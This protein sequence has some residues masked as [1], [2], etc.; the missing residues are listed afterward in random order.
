MRGL[1]ARQKDAGQIS[2]LGRMAEIALHENLNGAAPRPVLIPH[3]LGDLHLHVKAELF[4]R[5]PGQQM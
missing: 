5:A 4:R 1:Q 2:H 3:R